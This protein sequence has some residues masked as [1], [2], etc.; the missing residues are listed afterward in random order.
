[1][2]VSS[3]ELKTTVYKACVGQGVLRGIAQ[4][5]SNALVAPQR[6]DMGNEGIDPALAPAI[7][8]L[9]DLLNAFDGGARDTIAPSMA[10]EAVELAAANIL[11]HGPSLV[12]L[13]VA[14][15]GRGPIRISVLDD[16]T[17]LERLLDCR[18]VNYSL[19]ETGGSLELVAHGV[20][21]ETKTA[22][23]GGFEVDEIQWAQLVAF[24][25]KTLVLSS[26]LTRADA[27]AGLNDND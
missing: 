22:P 13:A 9:I 21:P 7:G 17:W 8:R 2:H 26:D 14:F 1:M 20:E 16:R 25:N 11:D 10:D 15:C 6:A 19:N 18:G 4:D 24:A 5:I 23:S 27:G 12:D 3:N